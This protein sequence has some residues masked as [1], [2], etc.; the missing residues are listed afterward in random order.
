[1]VTTS[2]PLSDTYAVINVALADGTVI[3]S[4]QPAGY[5]GTWTASKVEK[6]GFHATITTMIDG[7][8][9]KG[10]FMLYNNQS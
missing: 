3:V 2:T 5:K 7:K 10:S 6:D 9:F 1:M 4:N 8:L